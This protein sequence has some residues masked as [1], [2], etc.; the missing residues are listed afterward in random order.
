MG[1]FTSTTRGQHRTQTLLRVGGWVPL[2]FMEQ[3]DPLT[4][5]SQSSMFLPLI[6]T[7]KEKHQQMV[8][9]WI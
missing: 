2:E 9:N 8:A 6:L 4:V 3:A 5:P 7:R 1:P